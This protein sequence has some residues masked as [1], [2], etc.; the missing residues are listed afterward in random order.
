MTTFSTDLALEIYTED[1]PG[2]WPLTYEEWADRARNSLSTEAFDYVAGSAGREETARANRTAFDNWRLRVRMLRTAP[3]RR[4]HTEI[5]GTPTP[6]PIMLAPIGV[7]EI[8]HPA[9][10]LA[11]AAAASEAQV[12]FIASTASSTSLE[13]IAA[14]MGEAPRWFQLYPGARHDVDASL[15]RRAEDAGYSA[16]VVSL[17]TTLPGFRPRDL[18]KSYLPF[19][20]GMGLANFRTDPVFRSGVNVDDV[21][22]L[23]REFLRTM[24]VPHLAWD[25]VARLIE[26]TRLPVLIKGVLDAE[27]ALIAQSCGAA[28]IVVSNHGGRQV[29]GAIGALDALPAI[30]RA[31]GGEIP[32]LFDS[33]IRS[34][35]DVLKAMALGASG[36]LVGR[37]YAYGLAVAGAPGVAR[38]IRQMLAE[39]DSALALS[40]N[41]SV[42]D[43]SRD[44]V[45]PAGQVTA[46]SIHATTSI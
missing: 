27:D 46:T 12:P 10:E 5:L 9:A 32:V 29:D 8:L 11:S 15:I 30:A 45:V 16:L 14:V 39:I 44:S 38:V 1:Q 33:G 18:A 23:G 19:L 25:D 17:D 4:L 43:I 41:K 21:A 22:E 3:E 24:L 36:V 37:P 42:A 13:D 26:S 31:V 7:Q 20:R 40:G 35:S 2:R 34:G 6:G 28:G